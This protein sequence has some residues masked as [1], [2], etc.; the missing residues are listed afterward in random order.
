MPAPGLPPI[1][2]A[3]IVA[4]LPLSVTVALVCIIKTAAVQRAFATHAPNNADAS[5]DFAGVGAGCLLAGLFGAF[6]VDASLPRTAVVIDAGGRSQVAA[7][8]GAI[9]VA[10][11]LLF[12]PAA[13]VYIPVAALGAVLLF[14]AF[15]LLRIQEIVRIYRFGRFEIL[16]VAANTALVVAL[17][18]EIEVMMSIALSLVHSLYVLARPRA[19]PMARLTGTSLWLPTRHDFTGE[20]IPGVLVFDLDAP[21]NFTNV[22]HVCGRLLD[23]VRSQHPQRV[24]IH[25]AR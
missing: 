22:N 6:P 8:T 21:L 10:A 12:A 20:Q 2:F 1:A 24:V 4:L 15:G 19:G 18:V 11:V 13:F 25:A 5:R 16:L 14:V 23:A 7:L 3:D 17:R 9:L